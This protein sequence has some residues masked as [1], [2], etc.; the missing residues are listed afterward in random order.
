MNPVSPV[1]ADS[2][3]T[4]GGL[5]EEL[6]ASNRI[7]AAQRLEAAKAEAARL[8]LIVDR[9]NTKMGGEPPQADQWCLV[10]AGPTRD[11][12]L[13]LRVSPDGKDVAEV[14]A[15]ICIGRSC[16]WIEKEL[17]M[18]YWKIGLGMMSESDSAV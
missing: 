6:S 11:V 17:G 12:A 13:R 1:T 15:V 10:I 9:C 5:P 7:C 4:T 14:V 3:A 16:A 2:P 18:G 8:V